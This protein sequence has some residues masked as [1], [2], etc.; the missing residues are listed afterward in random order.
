MLDLSVLFLTGRGPVA[1]RQS[2]L[3]AAW[4]EAQRRRQRQWEAQ[5]RAWLA[6]QEEQQRAHRAALRA[7][8]RDQRDA[9]LI[10]QQGREEH[11]TR[12]TQQIEAQVA[13]LGGLL[14]SV[15][16]TPPFR[17]EQLRR[18][19]AIPP[20]NPGPLGV[21]IP[22]PDQG[23]YRVPPP[24]GL[25]SLSPAARREYEE[26]CRR[27]QAHFE[28]DCQ[29][30]QQREQ[31]R[32]QQLAAYHEQYL[33]WTAKQQQDTADHNTQIDELGARLAGKDP[34]A[35]CDYFTAA[36]Y[37]PQSG[38]PARLPRQARVAWDPQDCQ[39]ILDWEL[40][41]YGTVPDM[42]RCRYIKSDDREIQISRPAG[43]RKSMYRQ[44]LAQC[45]LGVLA[46]AFRA[47]HAS[48]VSSVTLNGFVT[49]ADPATGH[50]SENWLLTVMAK[51]EVF[52]ALDLARVD[53]VSCLEGLNGQLSSHPE[54]LT[55]VRPTRLASAADSRPAGPAAPAKASLMD[56]DP[57]DF[58]D[59]VAALFQDMGLE[60]MTTER[61]GDGGVDVR[62]M[63][64]DPIRGGKLVIQVKRYKTTIP[65]AP[66]RDLYGTMLH[67]G[68]TKGILV[69]T[70]EFGPSAQAFA[71]GKPLT[72][73]GGTQLADLLSRHGMTPTASA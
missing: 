2:G 56:M 39:L 19:V 7:H 69:S 1:R 21:P 36:L 46:G 29:Q 33:A 31:A 15:L 4:A 63:D 65:P 28:H 62:A 48:I 17:L 37:S 13:E 12:Q 11:A 3:V 51:R 41:G 24:V 70:A 54:K 5:Q 71:A 66:V 40:P 18:Q 73:I 30:A 53:P 42:S 45:A 25:R 64:P 9:V 60:V 6:T 43:E 34:A 57:I 52:A 47:D 50:N 49:S 8:A 35:I 32:M 10:Y 58:E 38:W 61:T 16:A 14:A 26:T 59:L 68:A 27:A 20:F 44:L 67:E 23:Y 72:L 22:L 55:P